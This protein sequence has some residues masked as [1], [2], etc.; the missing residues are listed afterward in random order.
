MIV[1]TFKNSTLNNWLFITF[2]ILL[3]YFKGNTQVVFNE[4]MIDPTPVISLPECEFIELYNNGAETVNMSK[5]KIKGGSCDC[6]LSNFSLSSHSYV[7][8]ASTSSKGKLDSF[9]NVFYLPCFPSLNNEGKTLWLVDSLGRMQDFL[10]YDISWYNSEL[11]SQGGWTLERKDASLECSCS[12][13]WMAST[14]Q[15][16]GTPGKENSAIE[17][18]IVPKSTITRIGNITD[19]S[20]TISFS[21][22]MDSISLLK[23]SNYTID[24]GFG[25][26]IKIHS[27]FP[28]YDEATLILSSVVQKGE[29]YRLTVLPQ[30]ANC[31]KLVTDEITKRFAFSDSIKP[32]DLAIN[33]VLFNPASDG[34]DFV[35]LYNRSSKILDLKEITI[36]NKNVTTNELGTISM[37]HS[38]G[39]LL[40]PKEYIVITSDAEILK[41]K[42]SIPGDAVVVELSNFPSYPDD[43]GIVLITNRQGQA[44]DEFHYKSSMHSEQLSNVEEVSLERIQPNIATNQ[45]SNW[46][47]AA[48]SVGFATPDQQ[49]SQY[50]DSQTSEKLLTI[51]PNV[52]SPD[53][54]GI[55]DVAAFTFNLPSEGYT[56]TIS[57][58]NQNGILVRKLVS[59][60]TVATSGTIYW[61]GTDD[62]GSIVPIG[63]YIIQ[64]SA[65]DLKGDT[66]QCKIT[67]TVVSK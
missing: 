14:N 29:I 57:I 27:N 36:A 38:Q 33:E 53:N 44:I 16:G 35:E 62:S 19:S 21:T 17:K 47:S 61:D 2:I 10:S 43:E 9:G 7:L 49:N 34:V 54:D 13:N 45:E 3:T 64:C 60:K 58:F 41:S 23:T 1:L 52:I 4:I 66:K 32:N 31:G 20:I 28:K 8:I 6:I 51:S 11:K 30:I 67:C 59:N 40:F 42:H 48:W 65:F 5:W 63:I 25:N 24:H 26:P 46:H 56:A 55:D 12:D 39:I 37:F 22:Q 50:L 15:S 18:V